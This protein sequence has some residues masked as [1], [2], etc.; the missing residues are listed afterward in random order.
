MKVNP[1]EPALAQSNSG[2]A[3]TTVAERAANFGATL[4]S[5]LDGLAWQAAL[6]AG[7]ARVPQLINTDEAAA[8]GLQDLQA[9]LRGVLRNSGLD[10]NEKFQLSYDAA[11]QSFHVEG[12]HAVKTALESEL[13]GT[14]PTPF[15][16]AFKDGYTK[17]EDIA[18]SAAAVRTQ[19]MLDH[20]MRQRDPPG[21]DR[22]HAYRFELVMQSEGLTFN[23]MP[24]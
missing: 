19:Y 17:L 2:S 8:G 22:G 11:N 23:L 1:A 24:L 14:P 21:G 13:N 4:Q 12:G 16:T 18:S 10:Q 7:H 3:Q 6:A 9:R 20:G 15:S 5:A